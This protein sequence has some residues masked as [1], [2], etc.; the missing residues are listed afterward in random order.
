MY[1]PFFTLAS[2]AA[3]GESKNGENPSIRSRVQSEQ[4][5]SRSSGAEFGSGGRFF[6]RF[7][8][9]NFGES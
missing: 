1:V 8:V 2:E 9:E 5:K 3:R 6:R 4:K 7:Q